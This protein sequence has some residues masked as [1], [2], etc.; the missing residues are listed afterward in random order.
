MSFI[1][2]VQT[3][4]NDVII[5]VMGA[6]GKN[7]YLKAISGGMMSSLPITVGAAIFS[8][9][10]SFPYEPY[11]DFIKSIGLSEQLN[12]VSTGTLSLLA[13]YVA[14]LIAYRFA[15]N[16]GIDPLPA[17]I[18]SLA[19]FFIVIPQSV[20]EQD[21]IISAL[22]LDYLGGAGIFVAM[23]L[24]LL[25]AKIYCTCVKKGI[26]IKMPES[27]PSMVSKSLTPVIIG[28]IIAVVAFAIR[29]G[30]AIT[31]FGSIFNFITVVVAKPIMAIGTS[32][33]AL[34][35]IFTIVNFL[36]FF[37]IHPSPIT[38][39]IYPIL[40]AMITANVTAFQNGQP[41]PYLDAIVVYTSLGIG[42]TGG[43]LGLAVVMFIFAKSERYKMMAKVGLV[44]N[45]FNINEPLIFGM[46]I[47]MNPLMFVPMVAN[48]AVS[49]VI[50]WLFVKAGFIT[51]M[52][53]AVQ[54][55]LP[56]TTPT[57]V[58]GLL[59]GGLPFFIILLTCFI[60]GTLIYLPFFMIL[61]KKELI[62]EKNISE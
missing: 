44:P 26:V 16:E 45:I 46:P 22:P 15:E 54:L 57:I 52:N 58:Q 61:D 33:L 60:V 19:T 9:L 2:N 24:S 51:T 42:G 11:I 53:S 40:I 41:L 32:I 10:G 37:G 31:S 25:I 27:V 39:L 48:P 14:F 62:S 12:A 50:A 20:K 5:P 47:M 18:F 23:I 8:L 49:G 1:K 3:K 43:T 30:F 17:G 21:K 38:N 55:G 35:F 6:L 59:I 34:I 13:V 29:Y 56:W 28:I 4:M 36:W 7:K